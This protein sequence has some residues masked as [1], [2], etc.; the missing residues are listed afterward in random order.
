MKTDRHCFFFSLVEMRVAN[1]PINYTYS[2][3]GCVRLPIIQAYCEKHNYQL[4]TG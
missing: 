3:I 1:Y 2:Y 4:V